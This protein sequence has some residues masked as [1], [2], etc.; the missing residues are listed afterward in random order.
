MRPKFTGGSTGA[1]TTA[2]GPFVDVLAA[3]TSVLTALKTARTSIQTFR[4]KSTPSSADITTA[5]HDI[6]QIKNAIQFLEREVKAHSAALRA[7]GHLTDIK[8]LIQ[9][10]RDT[11]TILE[12]ILFGARRG[13]TPSKGGRRRHTAGFEAAL[14]QP[15]ARLWM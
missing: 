5:E 13:G 14:Q 3:Q 4:T 1:L 6:T 11:K 7:S 10:A 2:S 9:T 15:S 12:G 8:K